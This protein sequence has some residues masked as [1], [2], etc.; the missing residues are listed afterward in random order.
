[1]SITVGELNMATI[2]KKTAPAKGSVKTAAKNKKAKGSPQPARPTVRV[3]RPM[4][5][6]ARGR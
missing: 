4:G 1:V 6:Q 2:K 3:V 5:M